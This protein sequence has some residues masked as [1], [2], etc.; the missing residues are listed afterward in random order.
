MIY[1]RGNSDYAAIY[2]AACNPDQQ[3]G[4]VTEEEYDDMLGCVPPVYLRGVD[5]FLVGEALTRGPLGTV[6]ANYFQRG[7]QFFA[8]YHL[9]RA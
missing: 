8:R 6:Y 4:E 9:H 3:P 5:G 7:G 2:A 1:Q